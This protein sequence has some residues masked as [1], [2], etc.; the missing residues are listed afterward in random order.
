MQGRSREFKMSHTHTHHTHLHEFSNAFSFRK[1]RHY[2]SC[3]SVSKYTQ[4]AIENKPIVGTTLS[5]QLIMDIQSL[6]DIFKEAESRMVVLQ[7]THQTV[8]RK[9]SVLHKKTQETEKSWEMES[10]PYGRTHQLV[11]QFQMGQPKNRAY[12]WC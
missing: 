7:W 10:P 9:T 12:K 2:A 4:Y 6:I 5:S 8:W 1:K 11:V 3:N